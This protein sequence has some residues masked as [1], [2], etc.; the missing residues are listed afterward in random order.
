M[1]DLYE[2]DLTALDERMTKNVSK[3]MFVFYIFLAIVSL[4][5]GVSM[6]KYQLTFLTCAIIDLSLFSLC[7]FLSKAMMEYRKTK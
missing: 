7:V 1:E 5:D 4:F 2:E 3:I 6:F